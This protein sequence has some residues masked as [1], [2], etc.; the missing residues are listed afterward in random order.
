MLDVGGGTCIPGRM[1]MGQYIH[2]QSSSVFP[3]T[4]LAHSAAMPLQGEL[5]GFAL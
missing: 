5:Y 4:L 1:W 3:R 2:L